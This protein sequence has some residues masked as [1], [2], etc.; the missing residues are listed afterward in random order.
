MKHSADLSRHKCGLF[1]IGILPDINGIQL[2]TRFR[3]R[4]VGDTL[5][6]GFL[7]SVIQSANLRAHTG[8]KDI[9]HPGDHL[10]AGTEV[11]AQQ[12]LPA[13]SRSSLRNGLILMVFFQEDPR[14]RQTELIDGLFHVANQKTVIPLF[15]QRA[16]D[17][18]LDPV[19]VLIF[20][21][22][23]LPVAAADLS[24]SCCGIAPGPSQQQVQGLVFQVAEIQDPPAAL[25]CLIIPV[26]LFHQRDQAPCSDG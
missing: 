9:V 25:C 13:F 26:K 2:D 5:P 7:F 4:F 16:E 23:D 8:P 12:H 1:R 10:G 24:R 14:I 21:H 3:Q 15:R 18:I 17:G 11:V 6:K 20:I 19:G 22:Q